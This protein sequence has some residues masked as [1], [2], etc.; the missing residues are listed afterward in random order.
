[1]ARF[2]DEEYG[3]TGAGTPGAAPVPGVTPGVGASPAAEVTGA[4]PA[5]SPGASPA[6]ASAGEKVDAVIVGCGASGSLLAAK[7]AT[8]GKSV[9]ILEAGPN[10]GLKDMVSSQIWSRRWRWNGAETENG[11]AVGAGFNNGWGGGGSASH[12]YAVWLRLHEEDFEVTSRFGVGNDWPFSYADLRPYYDR[13]Q[14]EVGISGDAEAEVWRPEGDPYPMPPLRSLGQGRAIARGFAAIGVRTAPTPVAI[15]SVAYK[16]RSPCVYDGWCD[17]GCPIGALANP[18]VTYLPVA[19]KAG[20]E[21]RFDCT[22]TQI[23][24]DRTGARA[25]G[26]RYVDGDGAERVQEAAVVIVAAFAIQTPRLLL[27]SANERHPDG[28]ANSSGL[29]GAYITAHPFQSVYALFDDETDVAF[30]VSGGNVLSQD[31]YAKDPD[32]GYL[33]SWQW[34]GGSS[35][36]PNDLIGVAM[37]RVDLFG[38]ALHAFI[39]DASK[40]LTN[41]AWVGE[42]RA[43]VDNRITLSKTTDRLGLPIAKL[44]H[45]F[46]EDDLKALE[47]GMEQGQAAMRAG[48]AREVWLSGRATQHIMGGAIMG[49]DPANS[50]TDA[51]GVTH[52][53]GNLVVSGTP[54]FPTS[55]AVNPTFT[56]HALALRQAEHLIEEWGAIAR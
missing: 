17:A 15:N 47:A 23:L 46:H 28:L 45:E 40:H 42:N 11:G 38:D 10:L 36:K 5:A 43:M 22:A 27:L 51:Y 20:T 53:V 19:T 39:A 32:K 55:G 21:I 3:R 41:M 34:T 44:T 33:A 4:S 29:V 12:H 13:I 1:M 26:V 37:A 14:E 7:L 6:A 54:L 56:V 50:V 31:D 24:T 16:G 2:Q 25:V 49:T 9:V 48:G 8:A 30:G 35:V 18:L 52:D